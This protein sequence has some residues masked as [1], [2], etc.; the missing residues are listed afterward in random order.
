MD[1]PSLTKTDSRTL[2]V[3]GA[4]LTYDVRGDLSTA[5]D[6]APALMLIGTPMTAEGFTTLAGWF[7]DRPVITYDPRNAGRSRRTTDATPTPEDHAADVHA[8]L[9]ALRPELGSPRVDLFGSSG[10]AINA[11]ALVAAHP[12]DLRVVVAHEPPSS[13]VLPDAAV[14]VAAC[15][16]VLDTYHRLGFGPGL[17]KF[18]ALVSEQGPL[19]LE[20]LDRPDPDPAA[21]GLPTVDDGSRDDPL[22]ANMATIPVWGPDLD[23]LRSAPC[24]LV[25]AVG[26]DSGDTM[27]A[28]AP[29]AIAEALGTEA[30]TFPGDHIGFAGGELGQTGRPAEFAARLRAVLG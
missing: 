26:E 28:R 12:E 29:R 23:A 4:E 14:L 22:M 11:L 6:V 2:S 20:Y 13:R 15:A 8:L 24:R 5:T 10:G 1:A 16:D 17:A 25:L 18:I 7:E 19:G 27:A 30:V 21:F 9:T 3:P